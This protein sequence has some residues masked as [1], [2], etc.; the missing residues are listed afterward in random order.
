MSQHIELPIEETAMPPPPPAATPKKVRTCGNCHVAGHTKAKCTALPEPPVEIKITDII[1]WGLG[2]TSR[3]GN[4]AANKMRERIIEMIA[5]GLLPKNFTA[6]DEHGQQ[7]SALVAEWNGIIQR[8][9]SEEHIPAHTHYRV[10]LLAGRT[11]NYDFDIEF[12]NDVTVV[13]KRELEFKFGT[14]SVCK[15]PQFL[16]MRA[17]SDLFDM[18][19]PEYYYTNYIDTYLATDEGLAGLEKPTLEAY[20]NSV[21]STNYNVT[22][23]IAVLKARENNAKAAKN[24]VVNASIKAYLEAYSKQIKLDQL[25][26]KLVA[27]NGKVYLLYEPKTKKFHLQKIEHGKT[28]LNVN[29][30]TVRKGNVIVIPACDIQYGMLLRWRNHKGILMPAWQISIK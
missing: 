8:L 15:L 18:S 19:Y 12:M 23:F 26:E 13:S 27:Q 1:V 24:K 29:D 10:K 20:L 17:R 6:D 28:E 3:D 9:V 5:N 16:S 22:P 14:N 25:K 30:I 7:W 11:H 2:K 21:F 4:D